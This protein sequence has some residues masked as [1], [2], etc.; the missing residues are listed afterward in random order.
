[1][2]KCL[3]KKMPV[4]YIC[5]IG[6]RMPSLRRDTIFWTRIRRKLASVA[7]LLRQVD[8]QLHV[9]S[10]LPL[11]LYQSAWGRRLNSI[12]L[13]LQLQAVYLRLGIKKPL[14]WINTPTAWP[15]IAPLPRRGLIYQR[16][17]DYAAYDFDNFNSDYVRQ[18]DNQLLGNADQ[19]IHVSDELHQDAMKKGANSMLMPQ[20]VDPRFFSHNG[21]MPDDLKTL[22]RPIIG[23][24]GGMDHHKF[25]T[26]LVAEVA[27]EL[28]DYSIA[29][30]GPDNPNVAELHEL[31]NVHFLGSKSHAEIPAY[32]HNF[33]ICLLPTA[34]SEWGL[35]CRP[36]KLMEYLAAG[37]PVVATPTPASSPFAEEIAI[38]ADA[39]AWVSAITEILAQ[40]SSHTHCAIGHNPKLQAWDDLAQKFYQQLQASKLI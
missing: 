28:P 14:V 20:G 4:L 37:R 16:T 23:Y 25:D 9:Y 5:S 22:P 18:V 1:M 33:D 39:Q 24:V 8:R 35:K 34:Q 6:M 3:S 7:H 30:I 15:V 21:P 31:A 32:T 36:L 40:P 29:L 10:P 17:D 38:G 19:V 12:I 2:M 13:R 27:R 11:P 26:P